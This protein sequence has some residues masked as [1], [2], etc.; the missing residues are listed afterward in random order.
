MICTKSIADCQK[1]CIEY[2]EKNKF[3]IRNISDNT[4]FIKYIID[5]INGWCCDN[6]HG[7]EMLWFL[8]QLFLWFV[9]VVRAMMVF[10]FGVQLLLYYWCFLVLWSMLLLGSLFHW[11]VWT[12]HHSLWT[13]QEEGGGWK[14][15]DFLL[16]ASIVS[17]M[18]IW[19]TIDHITVYGS[20]WKL[21]FV[22]IIIVTIATDELQCILI[23][24]S[25]WFRDIERV[26]ITRV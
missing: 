19:K 14:K 23:D 3:I 25:H 6:G 26:S 17:L 20:Q 13:N 16:V 5:I 1:N 10:V 7:S 2:W 15:A 22:L 9:L 21:M 11:G 12:L 18:P 8:M 4:K 24:D